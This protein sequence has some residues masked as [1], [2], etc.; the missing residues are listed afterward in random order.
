ML[1]YPTLTRYDI[2][3]SRTI[4]NFHIQK[5]EVNMRHTTHVVHVTQDQDLG[6]RIYRTLSP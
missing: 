4:T 6:V 1:N 2:T 5:T 3:I